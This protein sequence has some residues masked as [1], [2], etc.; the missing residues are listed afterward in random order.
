MLL[1]VLGLPLG[2]LTHRLLD[3]PSPPG[4]EGPGG[5]Q[6][7][8]ASSTGPSATAATGPA[9]APTTGRAGS[10]TAAEEVAEATAEDT[11]HCR[12]TPPLVDARAI[13]AAT[14]LAATLDQ[15][16]RR[17]VMGIGQQLNLSTRDH[18]APLR[19]LAPHEV[20]VVGFDL[21]ELA[22]GETFGFPRPP[23]ARLLALAAEGMVLTASWHVGNPHTG[24]DSFDRSWTDL[25]ALV[26]GKGPAADEFWL[27]YEQKLELLR[28][29]QN[30]DHGR[31]PPAAVL[32]RPLHEANG[33]WF[34]WAQADPTAYRSLYAELQRRASAAGIHNIVWGWSA[35]AVT[36]DGITDPLT[37][38]PDRV[39]VAG[40]D[41]YD[42]PR[43]SQAPGQPRR[44][45]L[46]GLSGLAGRVPRLALAEVG[47]LGATDG[48]WDPARITTSVRALGLR[49]AYALLWFDDG[50]GIKQLSSLRRG[51]DWLAGCPEALCRIG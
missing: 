33:D 14:C 7:A 17:G 41:S 3:A 16:T 30:G 6:D 11:G 19:R 18:T 20:A 23:L 28:R 2:L 8:A 27:D 42:P 50:D 25:A 24:G 46:E 29:L 10:G 26:D 21:D 34:W 51:R 37:L 49:P 38:L 5:A 40:I 12:V 4:P 1:L 22:D 47:R 32:L 48:S 9:T 44:L 31:F 43:T 39:D 45:V 36:R 13:P 35:N 15:W